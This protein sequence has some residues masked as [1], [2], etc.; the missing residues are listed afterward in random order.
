MRVARPLFGLGSGAEDSRIATVLRKETV[1]GLLLLAATIV[2]LV[3]S[4]SPW[5]AAYESL[6]D[7][8]VG[9]GALHLDLTLA[10]WASDG[11]LAIFFFV[12][13]LELK[14]E[15]VA[16]DLRD[17]KRAVVPVAAAM[18]VYEPAVPFAVGVTLACPLAA[19][20][21]LTGLL[22]IPAP[23]PGPLKVTMPFWTG[24]PCV[25]PTVATSGLLKA[26]PGATDWRR[27]RDSAGA[28]LHRRSPAAHGP[29]WR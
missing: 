26:A 19:M 2:A 15:F 18:I 7:A 21:P 27:S 14:R 16:G 8:R 29:G 4:N 28:S 1:G 3:W 9:P 5:S 25:L 6:R 11:L 24:S 12:A 22:R 23:L 20:M 13:G 10:S 17:P